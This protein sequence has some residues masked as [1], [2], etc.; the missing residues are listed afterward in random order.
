MKLIKMSTPGWEIEF[1]SKFEVQDRLYRH[2]CRQCVAEYGI[3][4][5]SSINDMLVTI[6]GLEF[7][8][9]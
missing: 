1:P 8:V 2:I 7:D 4:E 3:T 5:I 9:E 6:C